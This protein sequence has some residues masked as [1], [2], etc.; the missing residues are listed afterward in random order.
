M[1]GVK[2]NTINYENQGSLLRRGWGKT[3]I[4]VFTFYTYFSRRTKKVNTSWRWSPRDPML[5]IMREML[6]WRIVT[7]TRKNMV[8][9]DQ[10]SRINQG[11]RTFITIL[12]MVVIIMTRS[13]KIPRLIKWRIILLTKQ[14]IWMIF[15][16]TSVIMKRINILRVSIMWSRIRVLSIEKAIPLIFRET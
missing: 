2:T 11:R 4:S 16:P 15:I 7:F 9:W 14:Y 3:L 8:G 12:D 5:V 13:T 1:D 10:H 6:K